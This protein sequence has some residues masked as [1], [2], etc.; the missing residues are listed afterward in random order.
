MSLFFED[1]DMEIKI[2]PIVACTKLNNKRQETPKQTNQSKSPFERILLQ[3]L[4][5]KGIQSC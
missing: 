3:Q 1:T 2:N 4:N 5:K